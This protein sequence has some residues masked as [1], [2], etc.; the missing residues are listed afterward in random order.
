MSVFSA[1]EVQFCWPR[2]M[3]ETTNQRDTIRDA[4]ASLTM[5]RARRMEKR[6]REKKKRLLDNQE[7]FRVEQVHSAAD[8]T[9][10]QLK[11]MQ[12]TIDLV[13]ALK[14]LCLLRHLLKLM[15]LLLLLQQFDLLPPEVRPD[16]SRPTQPTPKASR[17]KRARLAIKSN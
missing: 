2:N 9:R 14:F 13:V 5:A 4:R 8:E 11:F 6:E 1:A 10:L 17:A 15:L 12:H 7:S 3:P 16:N